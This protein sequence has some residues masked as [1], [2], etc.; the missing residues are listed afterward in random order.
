MNLIQ[1]NGTGS[2]ETDREI[3]KIDEEIA[4]C[5]KKNQ[6]KVLE[7]EFSH[8]RTLAESKGDSS[9]IFKLRNKIIGDIKKHKI[10]LL[11]Y[12]LL[13]KILLLI[14]PKSANML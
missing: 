14:H 8:L 11:L 1:V 10:L 4:E 13:Q 9:A 6:R 5:I 2:Q 12:A 3:S 7:K